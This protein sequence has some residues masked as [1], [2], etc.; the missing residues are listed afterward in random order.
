[1]V[2]SRSR[3]VEAAQQLFAQQG[4]G[5]TSPREVLAASGVGQGSLYHHFPTK[6]DLAFAAVTATAAETL[7]R[8][9]EQLRANG[10]AWDRVIA[11]LDRPRD[12]LAGC[13]VGR[14]TADEAV[15]TDDELRGGV[16]SYFVELL[17]EVAAAFREA[18]LPAE[19][20]ADR[21]HAAV[22]VIQG[23]YVLSRATQDAEAMRSAIR[24]FVALLQ[25]D[26]PAP[27]GA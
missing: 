5:A 14:L 1:M 27:A 19:A 24:G 16:A 26:A 20:A 21:A 17:D 23:G 7:G 18:G 6:H 25:T 11:Y 9:R 13:R 2:D 15:M 10:P 22:A 4:V 12:A 8:A 3:L